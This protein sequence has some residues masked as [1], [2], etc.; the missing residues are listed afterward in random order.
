MKPDLPG[1]GA[2]RDPSTAS[3]AE[4]AGRRRKARGKRAGDPS[5]L[6]LTYDL[7]PPTGQQMEHIQD[8]LRL[9]FELAIRRYR[10]EHAPREPHDG[11]AEHR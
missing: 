10:R 3:G 9:V 11:D 6:H 7:V 4:P 1:E 5:R 8:G 2:S